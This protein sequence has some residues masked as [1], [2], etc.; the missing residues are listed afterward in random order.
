MY[1]TGEAISPWYACWKASGY[2]RAGLTDKAYEALIQSYK[3]VGV[4][5][6]MFEINEEGGKSMPEEEKKM[7]ELIAKEVAKQLAQMK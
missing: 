6:E 2:A 3:S 1:P 4:F 7:E 5:G